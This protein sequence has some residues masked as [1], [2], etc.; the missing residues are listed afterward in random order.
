L[1]DAGVARVVVALEDPDP[2][3]RGRGITALRDAGIEVVIG[4]GAAEA[5]RSLAPYLHHR[6]TGRSWCLAKT[7][8]SLDARV[9]AADGS[10]RW[11]TGESARADVHRLRAESQA[12]VVGSGTALADRP[13]LTVRVGPVDRQPVRVLLDA[14]GRVPATGPLFDTELAPTHILTTEAVATE[15]AD[16]WRAAGAKVEALPPGPDG[17][18][19]LGA[20]LALLAR[21]GVVQALFEGGPTVHGALIT[22]GLVDR[23][24]AYVAP[25]ALGNDARPA[26]AWPGP[27]TLAAAPR[28]ELTATTRF[29][30][31][32]RLEYD[33]VPRSSTREDG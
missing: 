33:A 8:M 25:L 23:L 21:E 5:T 13:T 20:V 31:D 29:G 17:G 27:A 15:S 6:A 11:I 22:S 12:V 14:R 24:V 10:S 16:S 18:L 7:A 4:V 32:V 19:D 1:I 3:V 26:L 28:F 30:D 9:A 2:R